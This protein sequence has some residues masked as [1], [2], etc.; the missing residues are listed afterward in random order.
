MPECDSGMKD[1]DNL[2]ALDIS[3]GREDETMI[4]SLFYKNMMEMDIAT[5]MGS[6]QLLFDGGGE[7]TKEN[8]TKLSAAALSLVEVGGGRC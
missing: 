7:I 4:P 1:K 5:E 2:T 6:T 8:G 3:L